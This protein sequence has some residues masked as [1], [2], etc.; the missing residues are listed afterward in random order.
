VSQKGG[1]ALP[2]H[3]EPKALGKPE[4]PSAKSFRS[5]RPMRQHALVTVAF[6]CISPFTQTLDVHSLVISI[7][8]RAN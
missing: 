4:V 7:Y 2:D 3:P 1:F 8:A 5:E 6:G